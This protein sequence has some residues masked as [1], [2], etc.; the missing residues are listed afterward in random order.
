MMRAIWLGVAVL[1]GSAGL[2]SAADKDTRPAAGKSAPLVH[3]VIVYLK[4]DAPK[5][6]AS[7]II[8]EAYEQL[9]KIP[10]VRKLEAGVPA[11]NGSPQF[12]VKDYQV[13]LLLLFDN[14]A[15]LKT[16]IEHPIHV[17]YL[18][19]HGKHCEKV[20]VYDFQAPGK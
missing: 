1:A 19:K 11:K 5:D 2:A 12:G 16:Y 14:E 13:G 9:A 10:T 4:K 17:K 8:K 18:E 15:D 7:I 6:E 20:L 3:M